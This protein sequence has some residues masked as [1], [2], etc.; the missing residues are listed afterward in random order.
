[1]QHTQRTIED[2]DYYKLR[3]WTLRAFVF[4][5]AF[6]FG[7]AFALGGCGCASTPDQAQTPA[8]KAQLASVVVLARQV[9][10]YSDTDT[11]HTPTFS[12]SWAGYCNAFAV[13][14]AA[15]RSVDEIIGIGEAHR[16]SSSYMSSRRRFSPSGHGPRS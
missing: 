4:L 3:A 5:V 8:T 16:P 2:V 11:E 12:A 7:L 6:G 15:G 9:A 13:R 1:M 10:E 14:R